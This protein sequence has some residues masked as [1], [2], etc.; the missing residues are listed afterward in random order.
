MKVLFWLE[1]HRLNKRGEAAL[2]LRITYH[3]QRLNIATGIRLKPTQWDAQKQKAKGSS[4]LSQN[5]NELIATQRS[6]C[7]SSF[8][9]LI[10]S[11]VAFSTHDLVLLIKREEKPEI[12]WLELFDKH[13]KHMQSR[14]GVDYSSSTVRRYMSS[15]K[16]LKLFIKT[17]TSKNDINISKVDRKMV[18]ELDQFLRGEMRFSNNYVLK[19]IEQMRKV[20][21]R[22]V[23][24]GYVNHDPFDLIVFKKEDTNKE[25]LYKDELQKLIDYK[26]TSEMLE[27]TKDVFLF[28]CFTGLSHSDARKA[29]NND[30][31]IG[32]NNKPWLVLRRTKT[33]NLVQVPLLPFVVELIKK[34]KQHYSCLKNNVL[35]PVPA[36]QVLNRNLKQLAMEVGI[37]KRLSSHSARYTFGS[38]VLL[39]N[40]V[41]VEV[42]QKLLAHNSIKTT[43][44]YSKLSTQSIIDAIEILE[45]KLLK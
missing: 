2:K 23:V 44:L 1:K 14:V 27:L 11:D 16:N 12:G 29:S 36:N 15:R 40:G 30:L 4:E 5:I 13:L 42:A 6:K 28:M 43:M 10:K 24:D 32:A 7:I 45:S 3:S 37:N 34:Y 21:K 20:F 26:P 8:N 38:T 41:R 9:E 19:T 39:G 17:Q 35:M 18:A 22:G 25:F 33:N 31:K